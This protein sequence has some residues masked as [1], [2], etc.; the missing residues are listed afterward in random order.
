MS[1]LVLWRIFV[2]QNDFDIDADTINAI[3]MNA[4]KIL[5]VIAQANQGEYV[6]GEQMKEKTGFTPEIINGAVKVLEKSLLIENPAIYDELPP[7]DF[8]AVKITEFGK[9]V[10]EQYG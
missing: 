1:T 4:K 6:N 10:L 7:Y 5:E 3:D 2:L 8:N 9:Q